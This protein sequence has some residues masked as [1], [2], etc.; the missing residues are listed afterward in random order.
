VSRFDA[1]LT[2]EVAREAAVEKLRRQLPKTKQR[3][4]WAAYLELTETTQ[5]IEARLRTLLDVFG[6]SREEFRLMVILHRDGRIVLSEAEEKLGRRREG[7]QSTVR[8][9]EE[10]GWVRRGI[11]HLPASDRGSRIPK[12]KRNDPRVGREVRTLELSPDGERLIGKVLPRQE[13]IVKTL[14]GEVHSQELRTLI[15]ICGKL[16]RED[17]AS[18]IN[19]GAALIRASNE[20]ERQEQAGG[21]EE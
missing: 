8:R 9:A 5:W 6:V 19:F 7:V 17:D 3:L 4:A 13:E 11:A 12:E 15:R 14:M 20:F 21:S 2:L 1:K 18:K 16:R 10:L